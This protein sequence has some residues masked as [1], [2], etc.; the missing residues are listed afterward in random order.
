MTQGSLEEWMIESERPRERLQQFGA[1]FL[2]TVELLAILIG[3]GIKGVPV[4]QLAQELLNHFGSIQNLSRATIAELCQVKG[5]GR[6]KAM[7]IKVAFSL[8]ARAAHSSGKSKI[9]L[10]TPFEVYQLT[11]ETLVHEMRELFL[12]IL[13]DVKV[14]SLVKN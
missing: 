8:G 9:G 3:S 4:Q 7:Q 12:A 14:G 1:E 6:A 10:Q 5:V 13:L 2:S 11:K